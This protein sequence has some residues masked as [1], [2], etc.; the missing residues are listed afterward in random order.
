MSSLIYASGQVLENIKNSNNELATL[1][2]TA[3]AFGLCWSFLT[4]KQRKEILA[5]TEKMAKESESK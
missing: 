1:N 2:P 4:E 3:Y 5:H